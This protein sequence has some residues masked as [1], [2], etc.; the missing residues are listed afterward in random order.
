M[1]YIQ[2]VSRST[3]LVMGVKEIL[4]RGRTKYQEVEI[5]VF[6]EYG[7]SLILDGLVQSTEADEAI[8]HEALVHP[9]MVTHGSP[10]SVL[11]IGG[12]EGYT[13][14]EVLRYRSVRRA[15]MVDIDG[16]LVELAKK[17]LGRIHRNSFN[18]PRASVVIMD[19]LEYVEKT[20]EIFDVVIVDLTD[21]YGPEIGRKLY[22]EDFYRKLYSLTSDKGVVVT[23][24]GC[25]FYYPEYY[26]EIFKNMGN[27]Y[28]YVRGYSIWVPS[29]GYAVSYVIA[30]KSRDPGSIGGDDVNRILREEGVEGLKI[31]SGSL[32]ES[33]VRAP[34]I[35]PSFSTSP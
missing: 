17:Y 33:L 22:T 8:Y 18:D 7:L 12:G 23:Q 24:A 15:V 25:S 27:V 2:P 6:E 21:P 32:H 34:A 3:S 31:Y 30:S 29:F 26:Q 35:L 11:I 1:I 5:V 13:L 28:R 4:Y 20:K 9:A 10:G 19:G 14:R 16:E